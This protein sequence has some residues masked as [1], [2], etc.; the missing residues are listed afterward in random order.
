MTLR[1]VER[2]I[3][4]LKNVLA[5][6]PAMFYST[7]CHALTRRWR[8]TKPAERYTFNITCKPQQ[9]GEHVVL[10]LATESRLS[11]YCWTRHGRHSRMLITRFL[12]IWLT[13]HYALNLESL[14]IRAVFEW[15]YSVV[16]QFYKL[17]QWRSAISEWDFLLFL[18]TLTRKVKRYQTFS[19]V[20]LM[21]SITW[22]QHW[23]HKMTAPCSIHLDDR[24]SRSFFPT[25]SYVQTFAPSNA[26]TVQ[27]RT[28]VDISTQ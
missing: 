9:R 6:D 11:R 22:K 28:I 16:I 18:F 13:K 15:L 2:N 17:T 19:H 25:L 21:S 5:E 1:L 23:M 4:L 10:S 12:F 3:F 8:I 24:S 14:T 26:V 27:R 7:C 20:V